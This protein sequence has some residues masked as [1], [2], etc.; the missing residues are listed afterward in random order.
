MLSSR[1]ENIKAG[2]FQPGHRLPTMTIEELA[3]IEVAAALERQ[4]KT[5]AM[6]AS[7]RRENRRMEHLKMDG[8]E[9][10]KDLAD[11]AAAHDRAWDDWKDE[12]PKGSGNKANKRF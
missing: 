10:D 11:E 7:G 5:E 6:P 12:H 8:D 2:V 1:K 3:D 4:R 9:D